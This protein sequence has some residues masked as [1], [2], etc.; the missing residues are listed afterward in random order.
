MNVYILCLLFFSVDI[1]PTGHVLGSADRRTRPPTCE[2]SLSPQAICIIRAIMHSTLLWCC[3]HHERL[4]AGVEPLV[5]PHVK[6]RNLQGFLWKHLK[7][8]VEH[9]SIV[10]G[11]GFEEAA[12]IVHIVLSDT[13]TKPCKLLS[14]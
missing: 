1:T 14:Y 6:P 4:A 7:K 5:K 12:L 3:C 13:L 10:T 11:K 9:L 2:R 8:D